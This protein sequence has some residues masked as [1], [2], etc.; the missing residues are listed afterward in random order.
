M[1]KLFL[2]VCISIICRH[3]HSH[4]HTCIYYLLCVEYFAVYKVLS[5]V[6]PHLAP[7][8]PRGSRTTVL[9]LYVRALTGPGPVR[10]RATNLL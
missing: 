3:M 1:Q 6:F 7:Q 2:Y 10:G 9:T 5:C 8:E 4:I